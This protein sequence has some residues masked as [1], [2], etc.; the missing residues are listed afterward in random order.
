M[1]RNPCSASRADS[2]RHSEAPCSRRV[3]PAS[4]AAI[5]SHNQRA[6][7]G[8][9][10]FQNPR[11]REFYTIKEPGQYEAPK[12]DLK[13]NATELYQ[14]QQAIKRGADPAAVRRRMLERG[15]D[16]EGL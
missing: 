10:T 13:R 9:D 11:L 8:S 2:G 7:Q 12:R 5:A 16:P 3:S 4:R 1:Q 14:A 6:A 15:F